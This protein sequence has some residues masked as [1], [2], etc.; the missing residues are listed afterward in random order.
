V[1]AKMLATLKAALKADKDAYGVQLGVAAEG[2]E[3]PFAMRK[4]GVNE[5]LVFESASLIKVLI[6]VE[7]LRQAD[8]GEI[9]LVERIEVKSEDVVDYSEMI[10]K[11]IVRG[12]FTVEQLAEGMI[13][14]SDN[15]A[16]NLLIDLVGMKSVNTLSQKLRLAHTYL[17]RKM[18]DFESRSGGAHNLTTAADMV[19][20]LTAIW[21]GKIVSA[22]SRR[23]ALG[24]LERQ[25]FNTNI[26]AALPPGNRVAHKTG[27]L[28]D[29]EHDAGIVMLPRK[30]FALA[31]L[32]QGTA[33]ARSH[34]LRRVAASIYKTFSDGC[35]TQ[36]T[37]SN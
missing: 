19:T 26:P 15:T 36:R 2:L 5:E 32:T 13:T 22:N 17:G 35:G 29:M 24:I 33:E 27:E 34:T 4:V 25:R 23:L 20:L 11:G 6:L 9:S 16:T 10:H 8:S 30:A 37:C 14:V 28:D 1:Q 3:G 12:S 18:M 21:R 7:V 31:I